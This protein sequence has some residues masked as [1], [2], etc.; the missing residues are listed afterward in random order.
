MNE[1]RIHQ[2]FTLSV[3]LKG[4]H[5]LLECVGGVLLTVV[6]TDAMVAW[7][8]RLTAEELAEDP[9]DV[10]AVH[11]LQYAQNFSVSTQ[12]FY[13]W[14]LLSHGVVKLLLVVGLLRQQMWSYPASIVVMLL[15]IAYQL[16]RYS[17]TGSPALVLLSVF[18]L[19]I[20]WLIWHEYR[21][22]LRHIRPAE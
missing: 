7:V 9:H 19:L 6:S 3:L 15:F 16:Y 22:M 21:L 12:H 8:N 17:Y 2:V 4:A 18:D 20:I 5:A 13:A 11:L 10:I 14:Y 1:A